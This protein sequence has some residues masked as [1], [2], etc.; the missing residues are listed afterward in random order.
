MWG[1]S[2]EGMQGAWMKEVSTGN[3]KLLLANLGVFWEGRSGK[4][5]VKGW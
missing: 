4:S 1:P 3:H 2:K 5:Y